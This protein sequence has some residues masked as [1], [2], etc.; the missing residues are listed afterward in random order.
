MIAFVQFE[1]AFHNVP[2]HSMDQLQAF[3]DRLKEHCALLH[4][5]REFDKHVEAQVC[6]YTSIHPEAIESDGHA[7]V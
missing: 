6:R 3:Q 2:I 4:P 1:V 5:K 7:Q